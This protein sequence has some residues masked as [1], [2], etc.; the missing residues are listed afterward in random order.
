MS[1]VTGSCLLTL[2]NTG[3]FAHVTH[4]D[5]KHQQISITLAAGLLLS[6]AVLHYQFI[7]GALSS[8]M[9]VHPVLS[10]VWLR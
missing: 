9:L 5:M 1:A 8:V 4:M 7:L 6:L 2:S 3:R 10:I